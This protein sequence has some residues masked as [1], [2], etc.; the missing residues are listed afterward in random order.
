MSAKSFITL[1]SRS[2]MI[3]Q[4]ALHASGLNYTVC[5]IRDACYRQTENRDKGKVDILESGIMDHLLPLTA[6]VMSFAPFWK[7]YSI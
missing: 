2:R 4:T 1:I 6:M 3:L 5:V 7:L